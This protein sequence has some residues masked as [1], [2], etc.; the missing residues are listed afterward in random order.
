MKGKFVTK[1]N[2]KNI[3]KLFVV[4]LTIIAIVFGVKNSRK[5]EEQIGSTGAILENKDGAWM[6][7]WSKSVSSDYGGI[8]PFHIYDNDNTLYRGG[9]CMEKGK[10][11][12]FSFS[13]GVDAYNSNRVNNPSMYDI[14]LNAYYSSDDDE[15]TFY[16][17]KLSKIYPSAST[18]D[19]YT[20]YYYEQ[21]AL[22]GMGSNNLAQALRNYSSSSVELSGGTAVSVS[23]EEA[24]VTVN[25]NKW[26]VGP[27]TL[28]N[29]YNEFFY[30][31][32][33]SIVFTE[34]DGTSTINNFS[35]VDASGK[36]VEGYTELEGWNGEFY[37]E[38]DH[39]FKKGV[40]YSI[41]FDNM[42]AKTYTTVAKY[43]SASGGQDVSAFKRTP[44]PHPIEFNKEYE[45]KQ[46]QYDMYIVKDGENQSNLAGA[47]FEISSSRDTSR[48]F[49]TEG[50][51][52]VVTSARQEKIYNEKDGVVSE[53]VLITDNIQD[54][55]LIKETKAPQGY[56]IS[57]KD[58]QIRLYVN[59][60]EISDGEYEIDSITLGY[61]NKPEVKEYADEDGN[62]SIW[63][64]IDKE[65]NKVTISDDKKY[66]S[67]PSNTDDYWIAVQFHRNN[68]SDI[69]RSDL[70][71]K[72]KNPVAKYDL[73][74]DKLDIET[75]KYIANAKFNVTYYQ[76]TRVEANEDA[77][78]LIP[79]SASYNLTS[80]GD[81]DGGSKITDTGVSNPPLTFDIDATQ[82]V[83][84]I[85]KIDEIS[86]PEGYKKLLNGSIL[87]AVHK[88]NGEGI[89]ESDE[90]GNYKLNQLELLD[91]N[92]RSQSPAIKI[93]EGETLNIG[94]DGNV[95]NENP[96]VKV[97]FSGNKITVKWY[98][99]SIK[100][101]YELKFG[102]TCTSD[103]NRF[104]AG[105]HYDYTAKVNGNQRQTVD[106]ETATEAILL[107]SV[108]INKDKLK[109]SD[110]YTFKETSTG[111]NNFEIKNYT[112][113]VS[114]HRALSSDGRSYIV[115]YVE[116]K[117]TLNNKTIKI[118]TT[119]DTTDMWIFEDGSSKSNPSDGEKK[120]AIAHIQLIG[121]NTIIFI[122]ID[123][124][125][126]PFDFKLFK[127]S[128]D[129]E[130][131][132]NGTKFIVKRYEVDNRSNINLA[133][134]VSGNGTYV[135]GSENSG[136]A[137][138]TKTDNQIDY[139]NARAK[140][141]KAYI[142][143]IHETEAQE[144]DGYINVFK[145]D[146]K[147][148][149]YIQLMVYE[150]ESRNLKVEQGIVTTSD[151]T[152]DDLTKINT[153]VKNP[154]IDGNTVI[155]NILNPKTNI[156]LN[157]QKFTKSV[158]SGFQ[159]KN[160]EYIIK[161]DGTEI[162]DEQKNSM[163]T[164]GSINIKRDKLSIGEHTIEFYE[165]K[166]PANFENIFDLYDGVNGFITKF[167][168]NE[169][170][171]TSIV[172]N[173]VRG[174]KYN[175]LP[176]D[177]NKV[178]ND[179]KIEEIS[180]YVKVSLLSGNKLYFTIY[181]P[182]FVTFTLHKMNYNGESD[183]SNASKFSG[184][185]KFEIT[186]TDPTSETKF[187]GEIP[188]D[189]QTTF[190]TENKIATGS[191]YKYNIV[192][193]DVSEGFY[194]NLI[195]K[196][197]VVTVKMS[198]NGKIT[199]S[200]DIT[201]VDATTKAALKKFINL[202][203]D[204]NNNTVD[205]Y[206]AN[207]PEDFYKVILHKVDKYKNPIK[208]PA[209]FD[210]TKGSNTYPVI[211]ENGDTVISEDNAKI[212]YGSTQSYSIVETEAP[213]GYDKF[214]GH[215]ELDVKFNDMNATKAI[216]SATAKYYDKD[217]NISTDVN[218]S[219]KWDENG[220]IPIVELYVENES[221]KPYEFKLIKYA[222]DGTTKLV[223]DQDGDGAKFTI[224]RA[225][226]TYN[227]SDEN[228][229]NKYDYH[230][231]KAILESGAGTN[232]RVFY[233]V[234]ESGEIIDSLPLGGGFIY[235]YNVYED[236]TK[237]N[238]VNI[239]KDKVVRVTIKGGYDANN[240]AVITEYT[241]K[242]YSISA[243]GATD[244]TNKF[245][246][247]YPNCITLNKATNSDGIE[248]VTLGI[249][250]PKGYKVRLNKT[251]SEGNPVDTA[252][253]EA[254]HENERAV[255]MNI[256]YDSA[257]NPHTM[258]GM[259]TVTSDESYAIVP[260]TEQV[261]KIYENG[262]SAPY[263]NIL[264]TDKYIEVKVKADKQGVMSTTYT[265]KNKSDD[266]TPSNL[267]ELLKYI[268]KVE[269][270]EE[271][272][273]SIVNVVIKNP[274]IYRLKITKCEMDE[275]TELSGATVTLKKPGSDSDETII[276][277]G[278]TYYTTYDFSTF[279]KV[280]TYEIKET[281]TADYHYNILEGKTIKLYV[282]TTDTGN[283]WANFRIYEGNNVIPTSDELYNYVV[284]DPIT[285]AED[286]APFVNV[287]ILN[288]K[289]GSYGVKLVK[290][291]E[292]GNVIKN[293]PA[294]F[295]YSR[296]NSKLRKTD[297]TGTPQTSNGQITLDSNQVIDAENQTFRYVINETIAPTGYELYADTIQLNVLTKDDGQKLTIDKNNTTLTAGGNS[298]GKLET[299]TVTYKNGESA[300]WY[301]D[302]SKDSMIITI[303]V[304]NTKKEF[305][306][307]LRK[308]IENVSNDNG[309]NNTYYRGPTL[310]IYSIIEWMKNGTAAYY[311]TKEAVS[312]ESGDTV[313][314]KIDVFNESMLKGYAT[315]I[316]D[317]LQ[318]GLE[319]VPYT[320]GDGSIND[321][322]GWKFY[323]DKGNE[324]TDMSHISE[325]KYA[326]SNALKDTLLNE[327]QIRNYVLNAPQTTWRAYVEVECKV[328]E[329]PTEER[330][331]LTNRAEITDHKAIEIDSNGNE[332]ELTESDADT[333]YPKDRY[334][335]RDSEIENVKQQHESEMLNYDSSKEYSDSEYYPGYQDDDD[336]ETVTINPKNE[337][338]FGLTKVDGESGK[339]L[340]G[341]TFKVEEL[342]D[343]KYKTLYNNVVNKSMEVNEP[344]AS[345]KDTIKLNT[346][347][348][349]KITEISSMSNYE[350]L[351]NGKYIILKTYMDSSRK[352]HKGIYGNSN[353]DNL[354]N[355]YGFAIFETGNDYVPIEDGEL[356]NRI[357]VDINNSYPPKINIT[358][359]NDKII[360]GKY[361]INLK[362]V[363][364][365][366][367]ETLG[368]IPFKINKSPRI[369]YT[370]NTDG[371]LEITNGYVQI[372]KNNVN[373]VNTYE[374]QE[375]EENNGLNNKGYIILSKPIT[376]S[377]SKD[378]NTAKDKYIVTNIGVDYTSSDGNKH[379]DIGVDKTTNTG[380]STID[381]L[382]KDGTD[383]KVNIT[384]SPDGIIT[385]KAPNKKKKGEYNL[386]I[387]K[388]YI[389]NEGVQ[390]SLSGTKFEL[391]GNNVLRNEEKQYTSTDG[392]TNKVNK[393]IT[394]DN[395]NDSDVYTIKEVNTGKAGIVGLKNLIE[396][397]VDKYENPV[398]YELAG[399]NIV[400]KTEDGTII[401]EGVHY[402]DEDDEYGR[403][404][405]KDVELT[406]GR[407]ADVYAD[408]IGNT[409]ILTV[410]NRET[411]G[412]INVKIKKV[413][414]NTNQTINGVT[415]RAL[416]EKQISHTATTGEEESGIAYIEKDKVV[417][418]P[419]SYT[420]TIDETGI[421]TTPA[422]IVKLTD[423][424]IIL[425]F[426]TIY[427]EN[428]GTYIIDKN[429]VNAR[430]KTNMPETTGEIHEKQKEIA[431]KAVENVEVSEDGLNITI[432]IENTTTTNYGLSLRKADMD[433]NEELA[434][435]KF[436]IKE[437]G[438]TIAENQTIEEFK[439]RIASKTGVLVNTT[440]TYQIYET[441]PAK[442]YKNILEKVYIELVIKID[443]TGNATATYQIKAKTNG[444]SADV[445][446]VESKIQEYVNSH[447]NISSFLEKDGNNF[448]LNI[449][450]PKDV[451]DIDV[452][453]QKH[454]LGDINKGVDGAEFSIRR[455]D[456]AIEDERTEVSDVLNA[457]ASGENVETLPSITTSKNRQ[458]ETIDS[459][460]GVVVGKTYYYEITESRVPQNFESKFYQAIVK[461][462]VK[463]D[464]TV[465]AYIIT[466]KSSATSGWDY[467]EGDDDSD[468]I[469]VETDGT[470]ANVKW[471]NQV[472]YV[473]NI[474]KRQ[475]EDALPKDANGNVIWTNM[476]L[477]SGA[478]FTIVPEGREALIDHEQISA[479]KTFVEKEIQT[480]TI[481]NYTITE[482]ESAE[483]Y[484]N[485]FKDIDI[486]LTVA[487]DSKGN[488]NDKNTKI[489]VE[490]QT[491]K[492]VSTEA[493][494][495][496]K[497]SIGVSVDGNTVDVQIANKKITNKFDI[498]ILKVSDQRDE[499]GRLKGIPNVKFAVSG[500]LESSGDIGRLETVRADGYTDTNGFLTIH[501]ISPKNNSQSIEITELE[502]PD[503]VTMINGKIYLNIDT[504]DILESDSQEEIYQKL[505][506]M[507]DTD[508]DG[509]GDKERFKVDFEYPNQNINLKVEVKGQTVLL[510]IPNPT[511]TYLFNMF[512]YDEINYILHSDTSTVGA[513]F[514]VT[515]KN[516][517][518][519]LINDTLVNGYLKDFRITG[520][521]AVYEY[522]IEE[523]EAKEGYI[524][525]LEGYE[526][527]VYIATDS[528]GKVR[529][530]TN[531]GISG[532]TYYNLIA[533]EGVTPKYSLQE[534]TENGWVRL[535]TN[536]SDESAGIGLYIINPYAYKL[537][538]NKKDKNGTTNVNK[539]TITAEKIEDSNVDITRLF[540]GLD[541]DY[542]DLMLKRIAKTE[543]V[544]EDTLTLNKE[545][546]V[547][548]EKMLIHNNIGM[549]PKNESAHLWRIS[550]TDVETPYVNILK[551]KYIVV[552]AFY[553][554]NEIYTANHEGLDG[555]ENVV[556]Y[557]YYVIDND[558]NDVTADYSDYVEVSTEKIN[559]VWT[560]VVTVKDPMIFKMG[561]YK[562]VDSN[563]DEP[564]KGANLTLTLNEQTAEIKDGSYETDI[565]ETEIPIWGTAHA[566][567]K[568]S[569]TIKGYTN[570]LKDKSLHY[571]VLNR[572]GNL[573]VIQTYLV[574]ENS[575]EQIT[576][577]EEYDYIM[578]HVELRKYTTDEGYQLY[579]IYIENPTTFVFDLT[580]LG[581]DKQPLD[582]TRISVESSHS[583]V[584]ILDGNATNESDRS[585]MSFIEKDVNEH[586]IIT[587][588]IKEV[589]TKNG[590]YLNKF[591]DRIRITVTQENGQISIINK[592]Q[593][594]LVSSGGSKGWVPFD[595]L[596]YFDC[597]IDPEDK[598]SLADGEMQTLVV[599][600]ENPPQIKVE[601]IKTTAGSEENKRPIGNTKFTIVSQDS[602]TAYTNSNGI[603]NYLEEIHEP[604]SYTVRVYEDEVA[605]PKY[606]NILENK[607]MAVNI[608]V[609]AD[610][611]II[612]GAATFYRKDSDSYYD[613]DEQI[614]GEEAMELA[615]H[616]S[617][618][619]DRTGD[620]QKLLIY[621]D[622]PVKFDIDLTKQTTDSATLE[623]AEFEITSV[624]GL[625]ETIRTE[626]DDS[627]KITKRI[628]MAN[629]GVYE[630]HVTE[631]KP[632]GN[633][634]ENI[635][636]DDNMIVVFVKVAED[637]K[638]SLV[639]D[640]DGN[641]FTN[642]QTYLVKK[643]D[644]TAASAED[645]KV[646]REF[647]KV[648]Q[649][650]NSNEPDGIAFVIENPVQTKVDIIKTQYS[651]D[652]EKEEA[653]D[654][655][656]FTV[657]KNSSDM[658][659]NNALVD[660][661]IEIEEHNLR[662]S[663]NNYYD[664]Y[665]NRTNADGA[666]VNILDNK[667]IRVYTELR[668]DGRLIITDNEGEES[669]HYF[670]IY[671]N[672]H[673]G[674]DIKLNRDQYREL[675]SYIDVWAEKNNE[676]IYVLNVKVLN[677]ITMKVGFIKKQYG[678]EGERIPNVS[679]TVISKNTGSHDI[680]TK[681]YEEE[682]SEGNIK[683]GTYDFIVKENNNPNPK[684]VNILKDRFAKANVT[685]AQDGQ[686][687][688]NN[689]KF[690]TDNKNDDY[691]D[692]A[693]ITDS[694][695]LSFLQEMVYAEIDDSNVIQ[696][697]RFV[698]ENPVTL[699]FVINKLDLVENGLEGATFDITKYVGDSNEVAKGLTGK[700]TNSDGIITFEDGDI[701]KAGIYR[702][703][704][705]E[706]KPAAE[707][708]VNILDCYDDGSQYKVVVY[709]KLNLDGTTA[710]VK[711]A[712]GTA[713]GSGEQFKYKIVNRNNVVAEIP[714]EVTE[715]IHKYLTVRRT[716][717]TQTE[718]DKIDVDVHNTPMIDIDVIKITK[719][720]GV[721]KP[722]AGTLFSAENNYEK[723][724]FENVPA[725]QDKEYTFK[726]VTP[727]KHEFYITES[728]GVVNGGY[729]N[730]LENRYVRVYTTISADGVMKITDSNGNEDEDYFEIYEG[731]YNNRSRS[732]ILD[733]TEYAKIY[734]CVSVEAVEQEN[735]VYKL[736][737]KVNNP[738]RNY[739]FVLNKKVFGEEDI[740]MK[741]VEFFV[742]S[743]V[744]NEKHQLLT[745]ENGNLSFEEKRVPVGI[746]KYL[747]TEI[748]SSGEE[749]VNV[750]E[751]NYI[752][753]LLQ[754]NQD[755]TI[756]IVDGNG[757]AEG[758]ENKYYIL[759]KNNQNVDFDDTIVDDFVK[760]ETKDGEDMPELNL[761]I[762]DPERYNFK[763]VKRDALTN[764]KMNRVTFTTT[765][766][767]PDSKPVQLVDAETFEK[768][769]ISTVTTANIDGMDGVIM[770]PNILIDKTGTYTYVF[771]EESTDGLFK[772]LYKS[773][774][775]DI[776]IKID[777]SVEK[778]SEGNAIGYKVG[779]P[780]IVTGAKY[781]DDESTLTTQEKAQ[782]VRA[783]VLNTPIRGN[784][785]L[786]LNKL[787]SYTKHPLDGAEFDIRAEK[788]GEKFELYEDVDDLRIEN[789]I[790]PDHFTVSN[791]ELRIENIR[792]TPP[793]Y[794]APA[795][796]G[797]LE[798][799][800]IILTETKAP[801]GYML[802]DDPIVIEVTTAIDGKDDDAKYVVKSVNLL[803]G[804][805][806]GLVTQ[807]H[808]SNEINI[809]A[810]DEYFDLALR[811][812]IMS[813]AYSDRDD[814][815]ITEEETENRQPKVYEDDEL[816]NLNPNVTTANYRH[817]KNH[818]RVYAGQEVIY[819]LRVYNEGE[820]DGYAEEITDHLPEGLEFLPTDKFNTDRGWT[821]DL[822]D[823]SLRTIKTT[824]L[825]K[826]N[827]P[828]NDRF[829]AKN[830]LIKALDASTGVI[831]YKEI[832]IK[833]KVSDNLRP[834]VILTN[835]AEI[836]K[837]KAEN[838]TAETVDR[839][840][841]TNNADVP[842][843]KE[844]QEYKED[845][846]TDNREDYVP[847][848]EDDD[849]FEKL[850]VEEF[851]L[852]L[853]KYIT[854]INENEVLADET[855]EKFTDK[856]VENTE[857]NVGGNGTAS[858][859]A[860]GT[861][862]G[863]NTNNNDES[864]SGN[865]KEVNT[866]N[867][868]ENKGTDEESE[869]DIDN[870]NTIKYDREPRVN[871]S[872]LKSGDKDSIYKDPEEPTTAIYEH[873]KAPVEV[874]VDDIVTYT[875][876]IFNEGTVDGYASLIKD[877]IPEGVEFVQYTE[878]DGSVN[879]IYRWKMVDENDEEVTDPKKAKYIVSDYLSKDNEKEEFANIIRAFDP[880][881][882]TCLDSKYVQVQFRVICKQ[883]YPKIITNYAQI[884]D[885]S[886]ESGKKVIDRDSTPNEWL[887]E[888]DEDVEHIWV[889]YMDLAL[890][891]FIT[892]VTDYKTGVTQAVDTRIPQV[893]PTALINET[894][895]TAKYEHTKEP[896]LVHTNDVVIYTLRIFNEGS[897]D[898]YATQIKDDLP[899]GLEYLPDH[900]I[901]K[902][903]EWRLV[904]E[905]DKP[906]TRLEDATF[907]VTNYLSKDNETKDRQ[908][909]IESFDYYD[910][911]NDKPAK[912][913]TPE[914]KD[915]KI[916]FKVTE[917]QTSDR[918]L[919]NEAQISEQTDENGIHRE[920]RDSTPN[921]WLGE[922]D[923]DIEKVRVQYF[924]LALRKWV[925]KAIV[926]QDGE[927]KVFETGHHA[928]DDPED[929]VKVDLKKSKINKVVV[930]FEYQIR[931]T[932][933]GEI[934]GYA[935]EIKDHIPEGLTFD[936]ADNPTWTQ[937]EENIIV[938]D[939]LKDTLLKPG[940]SAE[941]TVVLRWINSGDNLGIKVNIAE[942]SKDYNDYGTHDIDS[943]PDNYV[944]GEDDI[945]DAPVMLAVK[946]GNAVIGYAVLGLVVVSIIA[947]GVKAV[948]KAR[949]E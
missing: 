119:D 816:F 104:F 46:S 621:I 916:A 655:T 315:E 491:G 445:Q 935:K 583:G 549:Q 595:E 174:E 171:T 166:A 683:P 796:D 163:N 679:V 216:N 820:I 36:N 117:D 643:K 124:E 834:G 202:K 69:C 760:V 702:Y 199:A 523:T 701:M 544:S 767:G 753:V 311:H 729:I 842:E 244:Y 196:N 928:E 828:N 926:T 449:P 887:D 742:V 101:N 273:E 275:K 376:L 358:I 743:S 16:R 436:T 663:D 144:N 875:L 203:F 669:S 696:K 761:Y 917:P 692:D 565:L 105:V 633:Q 807:T 80:L 485:V 232:N 306:L 805:N 682:F 380:E 798:T 949:K 896:V 754:V 568:E 677:P 17:T 779:N 641:E 869:K 28:N 557:K 534:I 925:T 207:V 108:Q 308:Y 245:N 674:S 553:R 642:N 269:V 750:L 831:D 734:E 888:D 321:K 856:V 722:L 206:I 431:E 605:D 224:D 276:S 118:P 54:V 609:Y 904:D 205:L 927:E 344:E 34:N 475:Y 932:N 338:K 360:T 91:G 562:K 61:E 466:A 448:K 832:E 85:I 148:I 6:N 456:I 755:G 685:V 716:T 675:Y 274:K 819:T 239:L 721:E 838:R 766:Y 379:I 687:T 62:K 218:V 850:I 637:G 757:V 774:A 149:A 410:E 299:N 48:R 492:T 278:E 639:A 455:A 802:L 720:D 645:E 697:I 566:I 345:G 162:S 603:I 334:P 533:K 575:N 775:E 95:N 781:I 50:S 877:D 548:S 749:F 243:A 170:G 748:K 497:E 396:L 438:A 131:A 578:S 864:E 694:E 139:I 660:E 588:T 114:V 197:I 450:N 501:G 494:E 204:S 168:V 892:G 794:Q 21:L 586:E 228:G 858:D 918:I 499:N 706:L 540:S 467:G 614:T 793:P 472:V 11:V 453:L 500:K 837:N 886:D 693:L 259:S 220:D 630:F 175:F 652:G 806:H 452:K 341:A 704:I 738:E 331:Y 937:L 295:S 709:V 319:F 280:Y 945:D 246:E 30:L 846:L 267:N 73:D 429:S 355:K 457:F 70:A 76:N 112:S 778:D 745:D 25:E 263:Y 213:A 909:L 262:V 911:E 347:Y 654:G 735:G 393:K 513:K 190:F 799:F 314:Y 516:D 659:L 354:Y 194:R 237:N 1:S 55:Y 215:I 192:E 375:I 879:D 172:E 644:G 736:N 402:Y 8:G 912:R 579:K 599:K 78:K 885:D 666:Y 561:L 42:Y 277:N 288:P 271:N 116:Y 667:Y 284:L 150:D 32:K 189:T 169:D 567:V 188:T 610:G 320:K 581:I 292:K 731:K 249:T 851:D 173:T 514:N 680:T 762:K 751:D 948:M 804:E 253:I 121:K 773:H 792:I 884:S 7:S 226:A 195:D 307:A 426:N 493:L 708:Y 340:E 89:Y 907:A 451:V 26:R 423:Y 250:N 154:T 146:G 636:G 252:I 532:A 257:G 371:T 225:I 43:F 473:L 836:T 895:T 18:M 705:T 474:T 823:Q 691:T 389:D 370:S 281:A 322:Y 535:T 587:Y 157:F 776:T 699:K 874:S 517:N 785:D 638:I 363:D 372:N 791:G 66:G 841:T 23:N 479:S 99:E 152:S 650:N 915:V 801:Q 463:E 198:G 700:D 394:K 861:N 866:Q 656:R 790:I 857:D 585:H 618:D 81:P 40:K 771:H 356:Y 933:E 367:G 293:Y 432:T 600:M 510:T 113:T 732:R 176:A 270:I 13:K 447:S 47:E 261:W 337:Y 724:L 484:Y 569:S 24:N 387:H 718:S 596:E 577:G 883:D 3:L 159:L 12:A 673:T 35:I 326:K 229:N 676:G 897:K 827:N 151:C 135:L 256:E 454:Q 283:V 97:S 98:N 530:T 814:A 458:T 795:A 889:T 786:I 465:N 481:Y 764:E 343:N 648:T 297:K 385:I 528:T 782:L 191:T 437:D 357:P 488:L 120:E 552:G 217:G 526:L 350:N 570:I 364:E 435:A 741:N 303:Y 944:A 613:N 511:K 604:G 88:T 234:L 698:I 110:V 563:I 37:I 538:L 53:S 212:E 531:E 289:T 580:K 411:P 310:N 622:D 620:V 619:V 83:R 41:R 922:D 853:R 421:P 45:E 571:I 543:N 898:A 136:A 366:T 695:T 446:E 238:Y 434:D 241:Y 401:H 138:S 880:E 301:I 555:E 653:L 461:V 607:Y 165:T 871:V 810:K 715:I 87:F 658:L 868:N 399:I 378:F 784:Y 15:E 719:E 905:N 155:L 844:M 464:K 940:E 616:C 51:D 946:T 594:R 770:I 651:S 929:V 504:S 914:Y 20:I 628:E 690:Y 242:I 383:V 298:I 365:E 29:P 92:G 495:L 323:D 64:A 859:D 236:E 902:Y 219:A 768:L 349:Y 808:T 668:S 231:A 324:I 38:F 901:N 483:G 14:M 684:Y 597:Y 143:E 106:K 211:T 496:A 200:Y 772:Y 623:G 640:K 681:T 855:E 287:R 536:I 752:F 689:I 407:T 127:K 824:F 833:C 158:T 703:E 678:P 862:D 392:Y 49:Y 906:V 133:N 290:T 664:I 589:R 813:V 711:D 93:S 369:Q 404:T 522:V 96:V 433:T 313:R 279:S 559:N 397:R 503:G 515:Y 860:E 125:E 443:N 415:F 233:G 208:F 818:V 142:Y 598:N 352:L 576:S 94:A 592:E 67:G 835:I 132:L 554:E 854:A 765:V 90:N 145:K 617:V 942:I 527:H 100:G 418:K 469:S 258:S 282:R 509:V 930:K 115:D 254:F 941:V 943:T 739:K 5:T 923:E 847:G 602:H 302:D 626:T 193:K 812:S 931:I 9:F 545:Y 441:T 671:E 406:D 56:T 403:I 661:E 632:A 756:N 822:N 264:G 627:G 482:D 891:K 649:N 400:E 388:V 164:K 852:A 572:N 235:T 296:Y 542:K 763:L 44:A 156:I 934:E 840:S 728:Q 780:N 601:L 398:G 86:A 419:E 342:V 22:W 247:E 913:E 128:S 318:D 39:D 631:I 186:R 409:V 160:G 422:N 908:N 374:V 546:T 4:I 316:T 111:N 201:G 430:I 489:I 82:N 873:T 471:A 758:N 255:A 487:V 187:N 359:P 769:D 332:I 221:S 309:K 508:G 130:T 33:G 867:T 890:R 184:T 486:K 788:D 717:S 512:K 845:E 330:V 391:S 10:D 558:G 134:A 339:E 746:Y 899:E 505:S 506:Q 183:V 876:E 442:Y 353:A 103:L 783:E 611:S 416:D 490:A 52:H 468:H 427:D 177:T 936:P 248:V 147:E 182:S 521:N 670:E 608:N 900:E 710:I 27:F 635:L 109:E 894:G 153:Y 439:N 328:V 480:D 327:C 893:D 789:A 291:D 821:Y 524:N 31:N 167:K 102:K 647:C 924:D 556:T 335:D 910:Y 361:K 126:K 629:P 444:S 382:T 266:T 240:N 759:D 180:Q 181:D 420:Y 107:E 161:I 787:D 222:N 502:V 525:V 272:G 797:T 672:Q 223:S 462:T 304:K 574:D 551:D 541:Q 268:D 265:I 68:G 294:T 662:V 19:K 325:A 386:Q 74:I 714:S 920:D 129:D 564:L 519:V 141:P 305:D 395:V 919:T 368:G 938:T 477:L 178:V 329:K 440:H 560:V 921:K 137:L 60:K 624:E 839:D 825:S 843:G 723:D 300:A 122:D 848:Q 809:V 615:A 460:K 811:K 800:N 849:D 518:D 408:I 725:T 657:I 373:E 79:A 140:N 882:G 346:T 870:A 381:V 625:F 459:V 939:Q 71:I 550:E 84:D 351:L 179:A 803:S 470:T 646:I 414:S 815:K 58:K 185:A 214:D 75:D 712:A 424:G 529:E 707:K 733:R 405:I 590:A 428:N 744:D 865:T 384:V 333:Q 417:N 830:N 65:G 872:T 286:G 903:Y 227:E 747:V 285:T 476:Q 210:V 377:I 547:T 737:L 881:T 713:F 59:K 123:E 863:A 686:L 740:N 507:V 520:P 573:E 612:S 817:V 336:K 412:K 606:V 537:Q 634:Y 57:N 498:K 726:N 390:H 584:H 829:N 777:I 2:I 63:M 727:G 539:A 593:E 251:D 413:M 665:E 77:L 317:Y 947:I 72:Y 878:G 312:V 826:E 209:K 478:T 260:G 591:N 730:V 688:C 230:E 362:K 348:T 582:G 425:S